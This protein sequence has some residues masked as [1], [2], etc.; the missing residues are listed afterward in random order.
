[1]INTKQLVSVVLV[2]SLAACSRSG[3]RP[4]ILDGHELHPALTTPKIG[5][6]PVRHVPRQVLLENPQHSTDAD[7][8][9]AIASSGSQGK[10]GGEVI[11]SALY[12]LYVDDGDVGLYGLEAASK[13]DADWLEDALREIWSHNVS[14]NRAQVHRGGLVL[15]VVWTDGVSPQVWEAVNAG[16]AARLDAA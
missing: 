6:Q 16:V 14:I 1:M 11:R 2:L 12:A 5:D 8:I 15:V 3:L 9:R 13:A 10:L 7:F 4:L